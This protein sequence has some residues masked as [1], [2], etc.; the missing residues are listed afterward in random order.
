[1]SLFNFSISIDATSY[2]FAV[3]QIMGWARQNESRSVYAANVHMVMEAYDHPD[4]KEIVNSADLVTPDGMPL[5]WCL[6]AKGVKSQQRVYGPT[7]M[8]E[9]LK[10]AEKEDIKVGF[11]GSTPDV[12]ERLTENLIGKFP[13]LEIALVLPLPFYDPSTEEDRET[14]SKIEGAG[15]QVLFVALGCPKQER[16]IAAHRGKVPAVMVGVGAA[17][18]FYAG[19]VKQAPPWMQKLGLE[20]LYRLTREPG[21]LW[22]RYLWNN[23]RFMVLAGWELFCEK[24]LKKGATT[25]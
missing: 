8:L 15:V 23:P 12:L 11:I 17:F 19:V 7:L 10:A 21:R 2:A 3:E 20:W 22:K 18:A 13:Q 16:W 5:V 1:M 25:N 9:V 24:V 6:R 14:C 4:F